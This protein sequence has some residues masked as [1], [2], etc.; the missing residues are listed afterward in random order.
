MYRDREISYGKHLKFYQLLYKDK[1]VFKT[2][3]LKTIHKI[4]A[5]HD[6]GIIHGN[7]NKNTISLNIQNNTIS[8]VYLTD[9]EHSY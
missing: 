1:T 9:Y 5:L 7:I 8:D 6:Q 4:K 3:I 2:F